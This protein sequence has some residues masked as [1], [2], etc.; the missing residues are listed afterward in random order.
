MSRQLLRN[1]SP[2]RRRWNSENMRDRDSRNDL[3]EKRKDTRGSLLERNTQFHNRVIVKFYI[4]SL[5]HFPWPSTHPLWP[6]FQ[7]ACRHNPWSSSITPSCYHFAND[8][9]HSFVGTSTTELG[10]PP[11]RGP[12]STSLVKSRLKSQIKKSSYAPLS[13]LSCLVNI[14]LS[15][16]KGVKMGLMMWFPLLCS[17]LPSSFVAFFF[18]L[19]FSSYSSF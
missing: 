6:R 19:L 1:F 9:R 7:H 11:S 15:R 8:V 4:R 17:K 12:F 2:G 5:V 18:V 14:A 10:P 16:T 13:V 3:E